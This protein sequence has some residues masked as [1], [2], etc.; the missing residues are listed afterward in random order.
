MAFH[1]NLGTIRPWTEHGQI[2]VTGAG[3]LDGQKLEGQALASE[4]DDTTTET[5]FENVA[6]SL[7]GHF[8]VVK[9]HDDGLWS[10]VDHVGTI[11]LFYG[12]ADG[13]GYVSDDGEWVREQL[14]AETTD[15]YAATEYLLFRF[16][17]GTETLY[18]GV[19][20]SQPGQVVYGEESNG[21]VSFTPKQY[22]NHELSDPPVK[23]RTELLAELDDLLVA[24]F[25]RFID[26]ADG[27]TI[28]VS[29]SGGYDS[30]LITSMLDRL[31][32][33]NVVTFSCLKG[34]QEDVDRARSV[35]ENIGFSWEFADLSYKDW[36]DF[37]QSPDWEKFHRHG[38]ALSGKP[39]VFDV[40]PIQALKQSGAIPDD[41]VFVCGH[42][43]IDPARPMNRHLR[44]QR[45]YSKT[46]F[47]DA[48]IDFH[49]CQWDYE[50]SEIEDRLREKILDE[51]DAHSSFQSR[52]DAVNA[53]ERWR[54][55]ERESKYIISHHMRVYDY[56]DSDWWLPLYDRD[57]LDFWSRVPI[58]NKAG[59]DLYQRY[60]EN[61]YA[62]VSGISKREAQVTTGSS[63]FLSQLEASLSGT[64][65]KPIASGLYHSYKQ[66]VESISA[67]EEEGFVEVRDSDPRYGVMGESLTDLPLRNVESFEG[68]HSA[69]VL[70]LLSFVSPEDTLLPSDGVFRWEDPPL[71][72]FPTDS[73]D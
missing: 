68:L 44:Q 29:L 21:I 9:N 25:E 45:Q 3:Y 22:Y 32:Y 2:H 4:F 5:E 24:A 17:T 58:D 6:D 27:R 37:Y 34:S 46:D 60:V 54:W 66:L 18:T 56:V 69:E 20:Q 36:H 14:A 16:V 59:R 7:R 23:D 73:E 40:P 8:A 65:L 70:G 71:T 19:H 1:V 52:K 43:A 64:D 33:E 62:D 63:K 35:A 53:Y 48:I 15:R 50:G 11:P 72:E 67:T 51:V 57:L 26:F 28:A 31:G 12:S 55:R 30:R 42:T 41:A 47:T 10:A 39:F 61:L 38:L 49:H 13:D